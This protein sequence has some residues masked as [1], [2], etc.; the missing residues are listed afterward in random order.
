MRV[1]VRTAAAWV[2]ALGLAGASAAAL[3]HTEG[4]VPNTPGGKAAAQRHKNFKEMGGA[5][6]AI[7]DEL[8]KDT[9][10]KAVV[11]AK[12]RTVKTL[13]ADL[14][15]WF[16]KGSGPETGMKTLA[17]PVIWTDPKG[18]GAAATRLQVETAKLDAVAQAG[19]MAGVKAQF[20]A[21]GKACK[22]CHDKFR[23]PEKG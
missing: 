18:F 5:F 13:A 12:A 17:K 16:P 6:K 11:A 23:K 4:P 20:A 21:T 22:N 9:P 14:P 2:L 1:W 7:M 15:H 3:A 10:D 19:D 8:K